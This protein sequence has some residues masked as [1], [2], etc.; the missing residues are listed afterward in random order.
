MNSIKNILLVFGVTGVLVF[1]L[2]D[3]IY[4]MT[5]TNQTFLEHIIIG[6]LIFISTALTLILFYKEKKK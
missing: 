1:I 6:W 3:F 5:D 2:N 4:Y